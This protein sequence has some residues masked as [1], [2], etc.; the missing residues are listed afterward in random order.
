M[1]TVLLIRAELRCIRKEPFAPVSYADE[2][3]DCIKSARF[4][5]MREND[6][7]SVLPVLLKNKQC[8]LV[9]EPYASALIPLISMLEELWSAY[10]SLRGRRNVFS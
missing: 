6:S 9:M 8:F 7:L 5:T 1:V 4:E 3:V 2:E 10:R